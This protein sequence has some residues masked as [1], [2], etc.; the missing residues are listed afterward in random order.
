MAFGRSQD[1]SSLVIRPGIK[2]NKF[3]KI[4]D[5]NFGGRGMSIVLM[6]AFKKQSFEMKMVAR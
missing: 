5:S 4:Y 1:I 6:G 2:N 3:R